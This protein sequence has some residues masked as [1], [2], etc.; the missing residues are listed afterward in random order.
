M[1]RA[2]ACA[3]RLA[4]GR[5]MQVASALKREFQPSTL[6][7]GLTAGLIAAIVTI[8]TEISL[9]ALIWSGPLSL[10]LAGGIGLM[11]FGACVVGIVIALTSSISGVVS[12]PQDTPAA[13]V[14]LIAAGIVASMQAA[15]RSVYVTVGA[16]ISISSLLM[17]LGFLLLGSFKA[18]GF[19]RYIPYP[20]VGGFLAGTGFL[21]ARG[22]F[23]V[24]VDMPMT[25]A[26]LPRLWTVDK[27]AEWVP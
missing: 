25:L 12:I 1:A 5:E 8:S 9:A 11:L 7:P 23:A 10:Y 24:M 16:A 18:S 13:I 2:A 14:A 20:V 21:L 22:A 27:L 15:G 26:N 19:V 17:G 6:L 3:Y 4:G